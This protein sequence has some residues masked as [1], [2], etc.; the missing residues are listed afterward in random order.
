MGGYI[1]NEILCDSTKSTIYSINGTD[2]GIY[3]FKDNC[4]LNISG[5]VDGIVAAYF[6]QRLNIMGLKTQFIE[7]I[8][9]KE[10]LIKLL[11]ILPVRVRVTN[12]LHEEHPLYGYAKNNILLRPSVEFFVKR[13]ANNNNTNNKELNQYS[14][15]SYETILNSGVIEE[16]TLETMTYMAIRTYD[17][18][19]GI[20]STVNIVLCDM[21][22][23]FGQYY[24]ENT[25]ED[26]VLLAGALSQ[27]CMRMNI[28]ASNIQDV[29]VQLV[30][31]LH[32]QSCIN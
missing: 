29:G 17:I 32:M 24:N 25:E 18:I 11:S 12:V 22:L 20:L 4:S 5:A 7:R 28:N 1:K 10:H 19:S 30:R 13:T 26:T 14:S 6:M 9:M 31:S 21:S 23:K 15:V 16:L 27:R 8:N 2:T 3:H